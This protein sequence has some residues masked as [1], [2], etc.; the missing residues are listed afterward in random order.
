[1]DEADRLIT[2]L[3]SMTFDEVK[4]EI[5]PTDKAAGPTTSLSGTDILSLVT[6]YRSASATKRR[7]LANKFPKVHM[8]ELYAAAAGH[9]TTF[10]GLESSAIRDEVRAEYEGRGVT[11]TN[12]KEAATISAWP[13]VYPVIANPQPNVIYPQMLEADEKRNEWAEQ[14]IHGPVR[15]GDER[16]LM[17]LH[18]GLV[19]KG[20]DPHDIESRNREW[21]G[22]HARQQ[23]LSG[24]Q[25]VLWIVGASH[26]GGLLVELKDAGW[27]ARNL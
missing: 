18:A 8:D 27:T 11:D 15:T 26:L 9:G 1:V 3:N 7:L 16:S 2:M 5:P 6:D 12:Y 10:T 14:A 23:D 17:A 19:K 4:C 22:A 24:K 13:G 21:I 20:F 25:R